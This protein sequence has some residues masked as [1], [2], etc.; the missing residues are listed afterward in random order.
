M[1]RL[2]TEKREAFARNYLIV[3]DADRAATRVGYASGVGQ[4]LMLV[5]EVRE[6]I[7]ELSETQ[8]Q[9]SDITAQRVMLE[10]GRIAFSDVRKVFR[11]D[12]QLIPVHE[13]DDDAAAAIQGIEHETHV[14]VGRKE[15]NLA[16]GEMEPTITQV[17]TAKIK[18]ANKD[19]ALQTLAKH[20]KLIGDEGDGVNA[21]ANALA[22]RL[23]TARRRVELVD[24]VPK[25]IGPMKGSSTQTFD[26]ALI[27]TPSAQRFRNQ[28]T[29]VSPCLAQ[30]AS[31][32][33]NR[34]RRVVDE[35]PDAKLAGMPRSYP[36]PGP[37][38][39]PLTGKPI[40]RI[41]GK[42]YVYDPSANAASTW[43]R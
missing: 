27:S 23:K 6:R 8:L 28:A 24:E 37:A 21:L 36:A 40:D 5:P 33:A 32:G 26:P 35:T 38:F 41:T 13:L 11:E 19:A 42:A 31:Q 22:D 43:T 17:R 7:A 9:A 10:L 20:F 1:P 16:T 30:S 2:S 3:K 39:D 12:G 18:R 14:L 4:Q 34:S 25:E 15:L 29:G